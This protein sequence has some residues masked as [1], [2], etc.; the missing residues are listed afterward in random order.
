M[1]QRCSF[2]LVLLA[3]LVM[4]GCASVETPPLSVSFLPERGEFIAEDGTRM[5]FHQALGLAA[6][7][8]YVILGEGHKNQCD[9]DM[10][11]RVVAG[12]VQLGRA[13]ALGLEMV[14]ADLQPVLDRFN[15]GELE[16][17]QMEKELDWT[18]TWGYPFS[19]FAP[20][21]E[22]ARRSGLPFGAL[23]A[24][25]RLTGKVREQGVEAL[26]EEEKK[27]F[28]STIIG[29]LPEQEEMLR[30][31]FAMHGDIDSFKTRIEGFLLVQS[32]WETMMAERA[33]ALRSQ[34]GRPVV[35]IAG[36]GHVDYGW[37]I[38]RRIQLLDPGARVVTLTPVR[39]VYHY[40]KELGTASFYCPEG[41]TSR[42]GMTLEVRQSRL[43]VVEI[44]PAG[45]A[46]LVGIRPGDIL[47]KAQGRSVRQLMDLHGAGKLAHDTNKGLLLVF[48]RSGRRVVADLGKLG[49]PAKKAAN[50]NE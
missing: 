9:H 10:Q 15:A 46:D 48:D 16:P 6:S 44:V 8:D 38:P 14:P 25:K 19:L 28:P 33:N 11:Q 22:E 50:E 17:A 49:I 21:F 35:V 47:I 12:L 3:L 42:L 34:T 41:Y 20:L 45:R 24:P 1:K 5:S 7:A 4:A 2:W 26:S 30:S 43:V 37:G 39:D 40:S 29:S 32:I 31:T 18:A 27:Y 13:P 23:N 36:S